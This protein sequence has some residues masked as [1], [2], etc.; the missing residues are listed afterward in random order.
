M[1]RFPGAA[2]HNIPPGSNDPSLDPRIIV[3]HTMVGT[4]E[5]AESLFRHGPLE[6]HFG[7]AMDGRVWQFRDTSRQADAQA[8]GND[9]CISIETEDMGNPE[10]RWSPVQFEK[11]VELIQWAG[12]T[13]SIP[14][15]LVRTTG[16]RGIGFHR[17]FDEWNPNRHSCPGDV[18]HRQLQEEL[19]PALQEEPAM[20]LT[21]ED[22]AAVRHV[23]REELVR[24]VQRIGGRSNAVYNEQN[25]DV[26]NL[27]M[28]EDVLKALPKNP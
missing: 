1:A 4:I 23:V 10:Q 26:A 20:P 28:A 15:T 19:L 3:V 16:D 11:L 22:L 7:V 25:P 12:R 8:A 17:Q 27:V 5:S 24:A 13:H 14:M 2:D 21:Q 18:R 9:R 6:S